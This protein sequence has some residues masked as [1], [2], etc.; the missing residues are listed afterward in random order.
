MEK[1]FI[2]KLIKLFETQR[3]KVL[4]RLG[5]KSIKLSIPSILLDI[6][7]ETKTFVLALTP[8]IREIVK[9]EGDLAFDQIGVDDVIDLE[10]PLIV[11]YLADNTIKFSK[12][13]NKFTNL[14]M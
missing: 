1:I 11:S 4:A 5:K 9:E 7:D 3:K 14:R 6:K 13:V 8:I 12:E 2:K 10:D